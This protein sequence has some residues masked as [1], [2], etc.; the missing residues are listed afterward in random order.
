MFDEVVIARFPEPSNVP[1]PDTA[2]ESEIVRAVCN[3][4]ALP[5]FP[6]T[7]VWSG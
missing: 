4:V 5:A 2:P 6:L 1:L 3:F 7:V